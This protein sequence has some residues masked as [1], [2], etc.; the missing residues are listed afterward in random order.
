MLL[1][2]AQVFDLGDVGYAAGDPG[3]IEFAR[4]GEMVVALM[5]VDEIAITASPDQGPRRIVVGKRPVAVA[6]SPDGS[7]VYVANSLDDTVSAIEI[8]SGMSKAVISLGPRPEPTA[9][10]RG[11]RLFYSAKVSH[12]GWMSCH[13]CHSDGHTNNL[14]SDTLGDGSFGVPKRVPSLL[15]VAATGP[16]TWTGSMARLDDQVRKSIATT[17][18]GTKLGDSAIADLKA[19]LETLSPPSRVMTEPAAADSAAVAGGR[20]V[21]QE[22]KCAVCH[23]S[24]EYTTP[25]RYDVG[26]RDEVGNRE[27]NPPSLRRVEQSR[28]VLA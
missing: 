13:S 10:Q 16:W 21:F 6:P 22:R 23:A 19:Y 18:H 8:K 17:M 11:E 12:D 5:G 25:G 2:R 9:A 1:D 4:G 28:F 26:L 14:A 20:A 3:A 24:P 27:F 15:G 7:M